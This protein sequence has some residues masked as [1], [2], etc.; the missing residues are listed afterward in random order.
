MSRTPRAHETCAL[1]LT[2]PL[3]GGC[4]LDLCE[5]REDQT[6]TWEERARE[7]LRLRRHERVEERLRSRSE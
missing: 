5:E 6:R 3:L 2:L 1:L 4:V 7:R